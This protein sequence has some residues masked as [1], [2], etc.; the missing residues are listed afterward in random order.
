MLCRQ[1]YCKGTRTSNHSS[2]QNHFCSAWFPSEFPLSCIC[3]LFVCFLKQKEIGNTSS[4]KHV[5]ISD[6]LQHLS[7]MA[8]KPSAI[9]FICSSVIWGLRLMRLTSNLKTKPQYTVN[10]T[11]CNFGF[12]IKNMP[13]H[14]G[15][16]HLWGCFFFLSCLEESLPLCDTKPPVHHNDL[17]T[18]CYP[19][20]RWGK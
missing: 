6:C 20:Y 2:L 4:P 12:P 15:T 7:T 17:F 16:A 11:C 10:A 5:S 18:F 19:S 1:I 9:V 14:A 3:F 8:V 13:F